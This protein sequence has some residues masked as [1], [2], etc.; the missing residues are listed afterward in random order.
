LRRSAWSCSRSAVCQPAI[1]N[2]LVDHVTHAGTTHSGRRDAP[3]PTHAGLIVDI[4]REH[5]FEKDL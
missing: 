1:S 5:H 2:D 3:A 4:N